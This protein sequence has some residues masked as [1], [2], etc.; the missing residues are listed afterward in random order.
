M[1]ILVTEGCN[2]IGESIIRTLL[3]ES[4]YEI[5]VLSEKTKEK[6]TSGKVFLYPASIIDNKA[7]KDIAYTVK[8][9]V[10]IN[11]AEYGSIYEN[12]KKKMQDYNVLYAENIFSIARVL[13]SHLISI[14]NEFVFNG[15]RGPFTEKDSPDSISYYGNTKHAMENSCLIN[16]KKC[17]VVRHSSLYGHSSFNYISFISNLVASLKDKK[18][19]NLKENYMTNPCFA[20]EFAYAILKIIE[21]KR[22]GIY[23]ISGKDYI[24]VHDFADKVAEANSLDSTFIKSYTPEPIKRF[25]L[26]NL[27][28][29]AELGIKFSGIESGLIAMKHCNYGEK[30]LPF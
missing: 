7:I 9:S 23:H 22:T 27:K 13:D 6:F 10:I 19:F 21:K 14:S 4:D 28:A 24:S 5:H 18:I 2:I 1:K 26:V 25:G 30:L 15:R 17:T 8:P 20:D 11:S 12:D 29:E 16:V 3:R